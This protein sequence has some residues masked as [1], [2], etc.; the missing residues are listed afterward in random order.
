MPGAYARTATQALTN[1]TYPYLENLADRGVVDA[2]AHQPALLSGVNCLDGK[3]T[4]RAVAD[5]LGMDYHDPKQL[6]GVE[7]AAGRSLAVRRFSQTEFTEF[8]ELTEFF[9]GG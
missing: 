5:A 8:L 2:I 4:Y 3:V 7:V 1:V 6:L 9:W